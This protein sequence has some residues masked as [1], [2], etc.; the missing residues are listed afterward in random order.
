[1]RKIESIKSD[2]QILN[3]EVEFQPGQ[4]GRKMVN[5]CE[6]VR[7]DS[8]HHTI[9]DHAKGMWWYWV[10]TASVSLPWLT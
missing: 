2:N 7:F 5:R 1:M 6:L 3:D 4:V 10:L 8:R 9:L